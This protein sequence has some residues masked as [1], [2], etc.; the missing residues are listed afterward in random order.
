VWYLSIG[1]LHDESTVHNV[2]HLRYGVS[3]HTGEGDDYTLPDTFEATFTVGSMLG[4]IA[5]SAVSIVD[6]T[7]LEGTHEFGVQISGTTPS[8]SQ[9]M[10][11]ATFT[12]VEIQDNDGTQVYY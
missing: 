11:N 1:N 6:D 7:D 8:G 2:F 9:I 3:S 12:T 4:D 10:T 5:C